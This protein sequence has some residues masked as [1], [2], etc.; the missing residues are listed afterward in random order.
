VFWKSISRINREIDPGL[1]FCI[2]WLIPVFISFSFISSK[3]PHYLLP[4]FP[5]FALVFSRLLD[6]KIT[7]RRWHQVVLVLPL[8]FSGV[9]LFT[10]SWWGAGMSIEWV[11]Q[12][13][14]AMGFFP[15]IL[16]VILVMWPLS[17]IKEGVVT[18][19]F[20]SVVFVSMIIIFFF[21]VTQDAYNPK[22]VAQYV[23]R[24]Q[25]EGKPIAHER[26]YNG[27]FN[28]LGRLERPVDV[29]NKS[30]STRWMG[31]HRDGYL[32]R[33]YEDK[34]SGLPADIF[35]QPIRGQWL[36]VWPVSRLL[37]NTQQAK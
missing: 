3:Q 15:V 4:I 22:P 37:L 18:V 28:F 13:N 21:D 19:A 27:E 30:G 20:A 16:A 1:R 7:I 25:S 5:A 6:D 12:I 9:L 35:K 10:I 2:S 24:L 34:P 14:P 11:E 33:Y 8:L 26:K 29:V 36:A 23:S 31:E 32:I 17:S